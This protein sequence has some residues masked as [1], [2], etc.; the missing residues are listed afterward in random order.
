MA[1]HAVVD[2]SQV[3]HVPPIQPDQDRMPPEQLQRLTHELRTAGIDMREGE[4][5]DRKLTELREMYEPFVNATFAATSS[6][7]AAS[8]DAR[9]NPG[10]QLAD[11][12]LDAANQRNR[13]PGPGR[14]G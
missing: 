1:R 11:Q 3:S 13:Q 14:R 5:V 2:L 12:C 10:G 8:T 9:F 4:A 6:C 7:L